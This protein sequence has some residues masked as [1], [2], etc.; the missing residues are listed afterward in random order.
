MSEEKTV[1]ERE[2]VWRERKAFEKGV[3]CERARLPF[4]ETA[5]WVAERDRLYPLPVRRR[6]LRVELSDGSVWSWDNGFRL[7]PRGQ[8][9]PRSQ[10][11]AN[12]AKTPEDFRQIARM[13]DGEMEDAPEDE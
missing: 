11:Q 12:H 13:L 2:A 4:T 6:P 10:F 7:W 5:V 3:V 9:I 8:W 1:T